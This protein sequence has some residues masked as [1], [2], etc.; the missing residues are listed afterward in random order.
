MDSHGQFEGSRPRRWAGAPGRPPIQQKLGRIRPVC[1]RQMS[2]SVCSDLIGGHHQ[3]RRGGPS[4]G[5]PSHWRG[6]MQ[7]AGHLHLKPFGKSG[8]PTRTS[9]TAAALV[10]AEARGRG[11][12][13]QRAK[14]ETAADAQPIGDGPKRAPR[15]ASR[16]GSP[17]AASIEPEHR[18]QIADSRAVAR[19]IRL[20]GQCDGIWQIVAASS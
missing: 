2:F 11:G 20:V 13:R 17:S 1:A 16:I 8:R 12:G 3:R 6:R 15:A 19:K 4:I 7:R 9:S 10:S 18:R 14:E 5:R